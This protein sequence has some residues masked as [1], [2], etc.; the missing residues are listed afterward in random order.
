[1]GKTAGSLRL[2]ARRRE[3][4]VSKPDACAIP[5][6]PHGLLHLVLLLLD[7][8]LHVEVLNP[9]GDASPLELRVMH[10]QLLKVLRNDL[11]RLLENLDKHAS[12]GRIVLKK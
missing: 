2:R 10:S 3:S 8:D 7:V 12:L 11:V 4:V 6:L 1:M 9:D 5:D